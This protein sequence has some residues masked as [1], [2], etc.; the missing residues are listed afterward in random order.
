MKLFFDQNLSH[1]LVSSLSDLYPDSSQAR[2]AGLD[3][4]MDRVIWQFAKE[5]DFTIVTL[6]S[7]FAELAAAIGPPPK[8]VWLR[9]GN[10]PSSAIEE[11]LR[12]RFEAIIAFTQDAEAACM[13]VY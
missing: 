13:E 2:L 8:V 3:T 5:N 11:R 9:C 7:D 1:K 6:D 10:Q 4:A 12:N